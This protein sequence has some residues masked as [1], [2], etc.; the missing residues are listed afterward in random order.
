MQSISHTQ[1]L[2]HPWQICQ[3]QEHTPSEQSPTSL[4]FSVLHRS[5]VAPPNVLLC[6]S[7]STNHILS[8]RLFLLFFSVSRR[9]CSLFMPLSAQTSAALLCSLYMC[10]AQPSLLS[11]IHHL[12][13]H[14]GF[15]SFGASPIVF[16]CL[17]CLV[18]PSSLWL[19]PF[20]PRRHLFFLLA[21]PAVVIPSLSCLS[22]GLFLGVRDFVLTCLFQQRASPQFLKESQRQPSKHV[23]TLYYRPL[24][25]QA[26]STCGAACGQTAEN[27]RFLDWHCDRNTQ[28]GAF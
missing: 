4:C 18:S 5:T 20:A 19:P 2:P 14:N 12:F 6:N 26:R 11:S 10:L 17:F 8:R 27:A 9:T 3:T 1:S 15:K 24:R 16:L 13:S 21:I 23:I 25:R 7:R 22:V 28:R